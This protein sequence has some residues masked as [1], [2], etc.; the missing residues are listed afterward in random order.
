M[1]AEVRWTK[2]ARREFNQ[3]LSYLARREPDAVDVVS[4]AI[5]TQVDRL[6]DYPYLGSVYR[7]ARRGEVRETFSANYRVFYRVERGGGRGADHL[8]VARPPARS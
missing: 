5:L 1:A 2:R 3:I 6:A 4:A 7:H 8:P